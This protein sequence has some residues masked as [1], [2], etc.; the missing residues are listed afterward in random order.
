MVE[1][2]DIKNEKITAEN[3]KLIPMDTVVQHLPTL[4]LSE[5]EVKRLMQGQRLSVRKLEHMQ[6][7]E[8]DGLYCVKVDTII[9]GI[10]RKSGVTI[11]SEF[12]WGNL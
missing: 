9:K 4:V 8:S 1:L 10:V 2:E 7:I 5:Q 12:V 6:K 3:I 11:C